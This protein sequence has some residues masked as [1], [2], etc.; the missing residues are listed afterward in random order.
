MVAIGGIGRNAA[1]KAAEAVVA[2]YEPS[3]MISAGIAGALS[4]TLKVGDVVQASEVVDAES[5]ARFAAGGESVIVTVSSVSGPA[6]K[7]NA[8]GSLEG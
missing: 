6:E 3:V 2:R 5:G 8:G 1:R 4:P 7:A